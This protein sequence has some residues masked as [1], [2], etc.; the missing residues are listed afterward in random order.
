MQDEIL[1]KIL[2]RLNILINLEF[3]P[4]YGEKSTDQ[5]KINRLNRFGLKPQ[6]I[7]EIM[8]TSSDKIS[9]QL[10]AIKK[11]KVIKHGKKI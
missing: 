4:L 2:Q 9:K 10:Y 1:N 7:A 5:E 11:R 3:T 8:G 6:E